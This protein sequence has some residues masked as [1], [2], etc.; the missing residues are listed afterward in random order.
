VLVFAAYIGDVNKRRK[1]Y[2]PRTLGNMLYKEMAN[3]LYGK[4]AQGIKGRQ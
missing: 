2:P 3:S 1:Q 4:L